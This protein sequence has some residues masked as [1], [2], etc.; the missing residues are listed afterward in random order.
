MSP[1]STG[2]PS[3]LSTTVTSAAASAMKR[4]VLNESLP[5]FALEYLRE[6]RSARPAL[7]GFHAWLRRTGRPILQLEATEIE[8]FMSPF[9]AAL[10][11][12]TQTR[13]RRQLF[14]YFDWLHARKLLPFNPRG[15]WLDFSNGRSLFELP[16]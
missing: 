1:T 12:H 9:L 15:V 10:K 6:A 4:H 3:S 2:E 16:D 11:P 8:S 5:P 13:S 7:R 14:R